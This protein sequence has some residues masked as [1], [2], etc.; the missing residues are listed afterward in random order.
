MNTYNEYYRE[1]IIPNLM[2]QLNLKSPMEVPRLLKITLNMG[3]GS[4]VSDK[5]VL[6]SAQQELTQ[7][8]GQKAVLTYAKKSIAN[9]KLREGMPIGCKVTLRNEKMYDF[10]EKL[11]KISLPRTRDFRG[12]NPK[13]FD[14][15]GNYT[16][17]VKE[18]II[19]PEIDFDRIDKIKGLDITITTNAKNN[20]EAMELFKQFNFPFK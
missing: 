9:F 7:I 4:A 19:F 20:Q 17:G 18:H 10:F 15:R 3:L 12:L 6:E 16:L 8:S 14:G 1:N 2:E 13:S 5:K 11:I